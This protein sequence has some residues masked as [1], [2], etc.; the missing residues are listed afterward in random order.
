MWHYEHE[1]ETRAALD[2]I[3]SNHFSRGENGVF[4][5]LRDTLITSGDYY[6]NLADLTSYTE[7]QARAGALYANRNAWAE[8]A[9]LNIAYSGRFSSDRTIAE[10]AREIWQTQPSPVP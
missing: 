10:Y 1:P 9:L 2:L 6:M 5:S 4:A 3:F 7:A 8:K